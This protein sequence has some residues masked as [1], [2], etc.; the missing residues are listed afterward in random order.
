MTA[1]PLRDSPYKGLVPF[2]DSDLD[3]RFFFGRE[4]ETELVSANLMA[5]RLTVLY[6]PS[7]VGKTSLL[8]AGV[9]RRLRALAPVG[10]EGDAPAECAV[11]VDSW[12]DDP[13]TAISGA[14]GMRLPVAG[15]RMLADVLA[16]R[17]AEL[18][19]ELYLILDQME[20]YFLYHGRHGG[21]SLAE[22]IAE[23]VARPDLHVHVLLGIRDDA[24]AELD[25]FKTRLPALFGN[26]LR[27]D[28]LNRE[29]ARAAI[30]QPPA[31]YARLGG[32]EVAVEAGLVDPLLDQ[33]TAGRI[34]HG[35]T[36]RGAVH[37]DEELG[38]IETPYL[39]LVLERLWHVELDAGSRELRLETLE[40]LGGAGSIVE[41]HLERAL[42]SL[43]AD[44]RELASRLFNHLVTPTGSKIAHS[45][46]DLARYAE[47]RDDRLERVLRS[48]AAERIV[49]PLPGRNGGGPRFE[50][51]HDVLAD[52]VL[53]WRARHD[54]QVAIERERTD[55]RRRHRRL[56]VITGLAL[57]ALMAT[58]GLAVYAFSQRSEAREQA[59]EARELAT[60]AR[61]RELAATALSQLAPDPEVSVLLALEAARLE[62]TDRVDDVLREALLA[63]RVRRTA[64]VPEAVSTLASA[65]EGLVVG[66]TPTRLVFFDAGLRVV[67]RLPL[68]GRLLG[69][70]EGSAVILTPAGIEFRDLRTNQIRR[71]ITLRPGAALVVRDVESGTV[72]GRLRMPGT[73][74]LAALGPGG[75]LL[76]VTDGTRRVL[77]LNT[78]TGEARYELRQPSGVTALEFGPA[79][80][81]L[82]TGGK[83]GSARL[84]SVAGG[85]QRAVLGGHEGYVRDVAFSPRATDVAT[86]SNDGTARVWKVGE[87]V[88]I[89]VI[90][91]HTNP[92][93]DLAWSPDGTALVTASADATAR[94]WKADTSGPLAS[95]RGHSGGLAAAR[96]VGD[97]SKVVTAADDGTVRLWD[98][99]EQPA[100]GLLARFD[101]PV[102]RA[103]FTR[104]GN[105]MAVTKSGRAHTVDQR[106]RELSRR[107]AKPPPTVRSA[108][109]A[110]VVVD[111]NDARI[112]RPGAP[113]IVLR[114]HTDDVTS[115]R[116]SP[117]GRF[118][119]TA[120]RDT[121]GRIWDARTGKLLHVLRGH[122][123]IVSDASFSPDGR[124]IVTAGPGSG[125]LWRAETGQRVYYLRGH[126]DILT[127]ASFSRDGRVVL[128]SGRDGTVRTFRCDVCASGPALV[129]V[130]RRRVAETRR[131]L[132]AAERARLM[133]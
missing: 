112:R 77:V 103:T 8:R 71:R 1:P 16:E 21:G 121:T 109:G 76:A 64:R 43:D 85:R 82:A 40:R 108:D 72:L 92:V 51:F 120:S 11:V 106:G 53:A 73:V 19:G 105:V 101:E 3:A 28:H 94:V 54:A 10:A 15:G 63:S 56:A 119:V 13:V 61:S 7:G 79:G 14:V 130:A 23:V 31:E 29:Q 58:A 102:T 133:G 50:I 48:L 111:G 116:F 42:D 122:F 98:A 24:L 55:A 65:G 36:G 34:E 49:R 46:G 113:E 68:E 97:G 86:A 75:T 27:L 35:L 67:R 52:A 88:P 87:A 132:T 66:A 117:N 127:S 74:K 99:R 123:A 80:Q 62:Q 84:W 37:E 57:V 6:G 25:A 30:V 78:L 9:V 12:R 70:R 114:G 83:D 4:R 93:T 95:L 96:F 69:V 59:E 107:Q 33:V 39:Q 124:W 2:D 41:Q 110:E 20:E 91:G 104:D 115:A 47:D 118:V 22:E 32:V 125:A 38:R 18:G 81:T 90:A 131:R 129:E 100:L 128:T 60:S 89:S 26:V 5:S 45:V 17:T 126:D 44:E